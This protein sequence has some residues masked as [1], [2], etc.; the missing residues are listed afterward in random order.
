[1][2]SGRRW[3]SGVH[4]EPFLKKSSGPSMQIPESRESQVT[5]S[6]LIFFLSFF[7][8]SLEG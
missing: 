5:R 7:F 8:F 1:M 2:M 6:I 4:V 3:S